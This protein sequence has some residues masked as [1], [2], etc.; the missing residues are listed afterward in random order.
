MAGFVQKVKKSSIYTLI[1]RTWDQVVGLIITWL[2]IKVLSVEEYGIYNLL[3]GTGVYLGIVSSFGLIP[4]LQRYLPEFFQ[5]KEYLQF[6]WTVR[7]G[8][9]VR[10]VGA[11]LSVSVIALLFDKIGPFFQIGDYF[12]YFLTFSIGVIF[13]FQA[14]LLQGVLRA[15]FLHKYA[16]RA[17]VIY[18]LLRL[19]LLC[20]VFYLGYGL[21]E[22]F[23]TN[24]IASVILL[25]LCFRYYRLN[26]DQ[27]MGEG[28]QSETFSRSS[29]FK[30]LFRYS[31]FSVFN[32][33]GKGVLDIST[34]LFVIAHFLGSSPLGYYSFAA[35]IGRL[36]SSWLPSKILRQVVTPTLFARY[37]ESRDKKEIDRMFGFLSKLNAFLMFPVFA[38]AA[39]FG[40][41]IIQYVF[42][43]K[44]LTAYPVMIILLIHFM[45][46]AFPVALPLQAVEKPEMV[47]IGKLFGHHC[48]TAY[49]QAI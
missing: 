29:L 35:R 42:D 28:K 5:R 46:R 37:G 13:L 14:H 24:V 12:K 47:L 41:E 17:E 45:M 34:D 16:V 33:I 11:I 3:V 49:D 32:Q 1:G 20:V 48:Q 23:V 9:I 38:F 27:T 25:G 26:A 18:S 30:R 10:G 44:Y 31:G 8:L 19:L 7:L 40:K 6:W 2:L 4:A 39:V 22:V 36:I 43:P 15:M 21:L